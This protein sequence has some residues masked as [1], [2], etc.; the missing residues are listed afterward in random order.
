MC[1]CRKRRAS[2]RILTKKEGQFNPALMGGTKFE[3]QGREAKIPALKELERHADLEA[4]YARCLPR[5][6]CA[7][8]RAQRTCLRVGECEVVVTLQHRAIVKSGIDVSNAGAAYTAAAR[9][10][11]DSGGADQ[12]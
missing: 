6:R 4:D 11:I 3:S 2:V 1:L 10:G 9:V 5:L 8:E 7:V 12:I